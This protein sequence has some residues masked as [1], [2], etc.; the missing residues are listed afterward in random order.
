MNVL[1]NSWKNSRIGWQDDI[2]LYYPNSIEFLATII[3]PIAILRFDNV[4]KRRMFHQTDHYQPFTS[5]FA[6]ITD[7]AIE[8]QIA[9]RGVNSRKGPAC[10]SSHERSH[11]DRQRRGIKT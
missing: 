4:I 8:I 3:V 7:A 9:T 6:A 11:L 10:I 5:T 2:L 1:S